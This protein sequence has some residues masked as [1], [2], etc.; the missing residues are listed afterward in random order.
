MALGITV[1]ILLVALAIGGVIYS[2]KESY[3][4]LL[5]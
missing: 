4:D 1:I 2:D 5:K 3:G